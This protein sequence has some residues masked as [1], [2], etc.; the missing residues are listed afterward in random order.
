MRKKKINDDVNEEL[1]DINNQNLIDQFN[2]QFEFQKQ[3]NF[4]DQ[5]KKKKPRDRI[6][7]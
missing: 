1:N 4:L 3:L 5:Q 7:C 2:D 6:L